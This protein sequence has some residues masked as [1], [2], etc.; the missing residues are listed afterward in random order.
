[1]AAVDES[2]LEAEKR[3][4]C[5]KNL[6]LAFGAQNTSLD[7]IKVYYWVTRDV[8]LAAL[9]NGVEKLTRDPSRRFP[10]TAAQLLAA[11]VSGNEEL[12]PAELAWKEA[13]RAI[14]FMPLRPQG[15]PHPEETYSTAELTEVMSRLGGVGRFQWATPEQYAY[16][17]TEF[18]K[19]YE[20]LRK[21]RSVATVP[22]K[23]LPGEKPQSYRQ[24]EVRYDTYVTDSGVEVRIP[25]GNT[26]AN[27]LPPDRRDTSVLIN[28][29]R[30]RL[31]ALNAKKREEAASRKPPNAP[32]FVPDWYTAYQD[33]DTLEQAITV[34]MRNPAMYEMYKGTFEAAR[35]YVARIE[36]LSKRKW[37]TI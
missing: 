19:L 27:A 16:L 36:Q 2:K 24:Y 3:Y 21:T 4:T 20:E 34:L 22:A 10:P 30:E 7:Q 33:I 23:A 31:A 25:A 8:S 13:E 28:P 9:Y 5:L 37:H 1:M 12:M 32:K 26:P 17:K 29:F 18:F 15:A 6:F 35:A 11:C 14:R